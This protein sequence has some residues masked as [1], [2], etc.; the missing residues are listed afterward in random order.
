MSYNARLKSE[1][2]EK[3]RE[4]KGVKERESKKKKRKRAFVG[5][6]TSFYARE[7]RN[8]KR[9]GRR[10]REKRRDPGHTRP[11]REFDSTE[12]LFRL[13]PSLSSP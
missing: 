9:R 11:S 10:R 6:A 12:R 5:I 3:E 2:K 13:E 7:R 8:E 1:E 4:R